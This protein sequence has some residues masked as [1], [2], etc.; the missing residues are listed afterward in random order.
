MWGNEDSGGSN[1]VKFWIN[2]GKEPMKPPDGLNVECKRKR[3]CQGLIVSR[4]GALAIWKMEL[5]WVEKEKT[6]GEVSLGEA[7]LL[8]WIANKHIKQLLDISSWR[9]TREIQHSGWAAWGACLRPMIV[10][11]KWEHDC[12]FS[13]FPFSCAEWVDS[14]VFIRTTVG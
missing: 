11:L 13:S 10:K 6:I 2:L 5:P 7:S 1:G 9:S 14:W 4:F 8:C 3:G 12:M